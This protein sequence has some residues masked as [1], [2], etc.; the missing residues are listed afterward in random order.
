[1]LRLKEDME[2]FSASSKALLKET[3]NNKSPLHGKI[4]PLFEYLTPQPGYEELLATSLKPYSETLVVAN[5]QDFSELLIF[6]KKNGLSDF[7]VLVKS[8]I[9]S[10][11][12]LPDSSLA[13]HVE[14][15]PL[16]YHLTQGISPEGGHFYDSLGV[17]F[18]VGAHKKPNNTF[19][20][21]AELKSLTEALETLFKQTAAHTLLCEETSEKLKLIEKRRSELSETRRKKEMDLVK[22]NFILQQALS[23]FERLQA[24]S[25]SLTQEKEALSNLAE[26][27]Q[28][29]VLAKKRLIAFKEESLS[30]L[31]SLQQQES[32][33]EKWRELQQLS[34]ILKAKREQS[35]G[36]E[37]KLAQ[38]IE[39]LRVRA[40][41]TVAAIAYQERD[42]ESDRLSLKRLQLEAKEMERRLVEAK[43]EQDIREKEIGQKRKINAGIEK[44]AHTLEIVLTQD[45]SEKKAIEEELNTRHAL[46]PDALESFPLLLEGGLEEASREIHSL[47]SALESAGAIN[48]T[49]IAEFQ[50]TQARFDYLDG[51]LKDLEA[52]KSD[53]EEIISKLDHESRKIFRK[54]F[55]QIRENFQKNFAILFNGG[56]ADLTFTESSDILE[57]GVEI[58]AKPPGKHMRSISLLSGGEK[59]LTA[60]ALLFS[61]FEVR[62]AP[63]C[64]LDEVDAPL[65]DTNIDRFT[66]CA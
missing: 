64:I 14:E 50:E 43:K 62:P 28:E 6:A 35:A 2:G 20:R 40:E 30:A 32:V 7:S 9:P 3:K 44:E 29:I 5:E 63:F 27:E 45:L 15:S 26:E 38:E 56:S 37:K 22:E 42:L 61:I 55:Q 19:Q 34:E 17:F 1:M 49:A 39:E 16:S 53:L 66:S 33:L 12:S 60:L 54:T 25:T 8:K 10:L 13:A 58:V 57:A 51:Q 48:M 46:L 31:N 59:C 21:R 41:E 18:H 36:H 4:E 11:K 47:R 24:E 23:D 52:S 65:D